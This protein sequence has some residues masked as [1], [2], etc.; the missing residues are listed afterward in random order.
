MKGAFCAEGLAIGCG[1]FVHKTRE[2]IIISHFLD[3]FHQVLQLELFSGLGVT[4]GRVG[5]EPGLMVVLEVPEGEFGVLEVVG[6]EVGNDFEETMA[7][8]IAAG[9]FEKGEE[10]AV[11]ELGVS[12]GGGDGPMAGLLIQFGVPGVETADEFRRTLEIAHVL[13]EGVVVF[14][15]L[16]SRFGN[17]VLDEREEVSNSFQADA[18]EDGALGDG[19]GEPLERLRELLGDEGGS[20]GEDDLVALFAREILPIGNFAGDVTFK[21]VPGFGEEEAALVELGFD[22]WQEFLEV[23]IGAPEIFDLGIAE[24]VDFRAGKDFFRGGF[25]DFET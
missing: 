1:E 23:R 24:T 7:I 2:S 10:G 22:E 25:S 19:T 9:L 8:G 11:A 15:V 16:L 17:R 3:L 21:D 14:Y 6:F 18:A 5:A 12:G 4:G 13:D 20:G